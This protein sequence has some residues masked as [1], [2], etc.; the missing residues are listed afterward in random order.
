MFRASLVGVALILSTSTAMATNIS[1]GTPYIYETSSTAAAASGTSVTPPAGGLGNV[2]GLCAPGTGGCPLFSGIIVPGPLT[3]GLI[4]F[5]TPSSI[6]GTSYILNLTVSDDHANNHASGFPANTPGDI[7]EVLLNGDS[8][9]FSSIASVTPSSF[10]SGSFQTVIGSSPNA[11]T[12]GITDLLQPYAD[13][14]TDNLPGVCAGY[15]RMA[16]PDARRRPMVARCRRAPTDRTLSTLKLSS[17]RPLNRRRLRFWDR[18]SC[19]SRHSVGA[20]LVDIQTVRVHRA[21]EGLGSR[22]SLAQ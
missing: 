9:G 2:G 20:V 6:P 7:F 22:N 18:A 17:P 10:S 12:I 4:S 13:G 8:L 19:R 11:Y 1:F 3:G 14:L 21:T 5:N 15:C 16:R